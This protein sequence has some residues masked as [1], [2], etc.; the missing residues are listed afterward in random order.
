MSMFD[1]QHKQLKA[2]MIKKFCILSDVNVD[3]I[4]LSVLQVLFLRCVQ[5]MNMPRSKN[6]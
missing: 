1:G 2:I 3:T 4:A 5:T 6:S